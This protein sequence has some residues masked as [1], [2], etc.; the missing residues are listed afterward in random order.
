MPIQDA[1]SSNS[2]DDITL[3]DD[4]QVGLLG[5]TV[6][7][8]FGHS[9]DEE[10]GWTLVDHK[11]NRLLQSIAAG[12]SV[13]C[14]LL[15]IN[16]LLIADMVYSEI[17][18]AVAAGVNS[19]ASVRLIQNSFHGNNKSTP[20]DN[21]MK[22]LFLA[23]NGC[24]SLLVLLGSSN[25]LQQVEKSINS[26]LER[27][28]EERRSDC[29]Y[30]EYGL[31]IFSLLAY[32][33]SWLIGSAIAFI[34]VSELDVSNQT[35]LG[36]AI[37]AF[38]GQF[39]IYATQNLTASILSVDNIIKLWKGVQKKT[40]TPSGLDFLWFGLKTFS[41]NLQR[42]SGFCGIAVEVF[43]SLFHRNIPLVV[44]LYVGCSSLW[45]NLTTVTLA[46]YQAL[47]GI[48]ETITDQVTTPSKAS[49]TKLSCGVTCA[50]TILGQCM[51]IGRMSSA[52]GFGF[53]GFKLR[54][55]DGLTTPLNLTAYIL[56]LATGFS[57][58]MQLRFFQTKLADGNLKN[59]HRIFC[60]SSKVIEPRNDDI[61]DLS[62]SSQSNDLKKR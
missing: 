30:V 44:L 21:T 59:I 36:L 43:D 37:P 29:S 50:L 24:D 38:A 46:D 3:T 27:V 57:A 34:G 4:L 54:Y 26:L 7:F 58:G 15:F 42:V 60:H 52:V 11:D 19:E 39:F 25:P 47:V 51:V 12:R 17:L 55:G 61:E 28:S 5:E 14:C 23:V 33:S 10:E 1:L 40:I 2:K 13:N 49:T 35:K 56:L 6:S 20:F 48:K 22:F 62:D 9:N 18:Y 45:M 53:S 41:S 31:N 8:P 32:L 16:M